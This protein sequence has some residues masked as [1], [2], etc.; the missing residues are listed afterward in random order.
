MIALNRRAVGF[1]GVSVA[2]ANCGPADV[3]RE[4]QQ[5]TER[6][7]QEHDWDLAFSIGGSAD[8]T[9]LHPLFIAATDDRFAVYDDG[10]HAVMMFDSAGRLLWTV[11]AEGGGAAE[12]LRVRDIAFDDSGGLLVVDAG[13]GR[14]TRLQEGKV[15]EQI[16]L[17]ETGSIEAIIPGESQSRVVVVGPQPLITIDRA[18]SVID[19]EALPHVDST[20]HP[21]A[22]QSV[23]A[24][25]N[26]HWALAFVFG[27]G[28]IA[29]SQGDR[30]TDAYKRG[31]VGDPGFPRVET[32][33]KF[34]AR[35]VD[36]R[37]VVKSVSLTGDV[38]YLH[39]YARSEEQGYI[40]RF[41]AS[42]GEYIGSWKLPPEASQAYE[43]SVSS[44]Q[45]LLLKADPSPTL[46]VYRM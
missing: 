12:F 43:S 17:A 22:T 15:V 31:L 33:G 41:R 6:I 35:L 3:P 7:E 28:W 16:S 10:R 23:V 44:R 18:G 27:G 24:G 37:P 32:S 1:L 38:V 13:N 30:R 9:F 26:E 14:I 40:D 39:L 21:M 29:G 4:V 8:S 34:N 19:R 25:T 2:L 42:D 45:I 46:L 5:R 36:A 20:L 11:G